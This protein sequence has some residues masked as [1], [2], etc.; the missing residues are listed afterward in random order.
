MEERTE[1]LEIFKKLDVQGRRRVLKFARRL[2][3][4]RSAKLKYPSG[5]QKGFDVYLADLEEVTAILPIINQEEMRSDLSIAEL[6]QMHNNLKKHDHNNSHVTKFLLGKLANDLYNIMSTVHVKLTLINSVLTDICEKEL[7]MS[8]RSFLFE[9][10][11]FKIIQQHP[12]LLER[13]NVLYTEIVR[14][15]SSLEQYLPSNP[16]LQQQLNDRFIIEFIPPGPME[17]TFEEFLNTV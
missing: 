7:S 10:R 12:G 11:F 2:D 6:I 4:E 17:Q 16:D 15:N 13:P 5:T 9:I 1:L 3:N 14:F 8:L